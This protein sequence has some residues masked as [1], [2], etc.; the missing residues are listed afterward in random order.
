MCRNIKT[1]FNFDPLE[2]VQIEVPLP[3]WLENLLNNPQDYATPF[4]VVPPRS[5]P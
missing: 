3:A 1:L 4:V 5:G 2:Q